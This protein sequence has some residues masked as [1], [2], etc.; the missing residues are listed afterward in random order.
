MQLPK[1]LGVLLL[2]IWLIVTGALYLVPGLN[3]SGSGNVLALFAIVAGILVLL[4]R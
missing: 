2:G 3:F 4:D 1:K